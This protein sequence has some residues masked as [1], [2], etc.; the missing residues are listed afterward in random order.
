MPKASR[1]FGRSGCQ[2]RYKS[3]L[4]IA[5]F[6]CATAPPHPA[7]AKSK[8]N[9]T[10]PPTYT[11]SPMLVKSAQ[12][13]RLHQLEICKIEGLEPDRV[14]GQGSQTLG[15]RVCFHFRVGALRHIAVTELRMKPKTLNP[16]PCLELP[17]MGQFAL[18]YVLKVNL[19]VGLS[20][21]GSSRNCGPLCGVP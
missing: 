10:V 15:L 5:E 11:L 6:G 8:T 3:C 14:P 7:Q 19:F 4:R 2:H 12:F 1:F 16:K 13:S 20:V 17:R 9:D 21:L 18:F